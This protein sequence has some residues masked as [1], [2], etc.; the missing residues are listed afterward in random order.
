MVARGLRNPWRFSF[1]RA[2]GSLV[3]GDVGQGEFEEIDVGVAG[4]YGWPCF[5][6]TTRRTATP[7]SC[8]SGTAAPVLT[9]S[10]SGD[11]FCSIT[12]GYVV[13]DPGLPTLLGRYVYGDF[14][15]SGLRSV[16]LAEPGL[17]RGRRAVGGLA[18]L[19]RR[20]RVRAD[21]GR[22]AGRPGLP[23]GG[24]G[25]VGL[26]VERARTGGPCRRHARLRIVRSRDRD[27]ERAADR[28]A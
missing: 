14:C 22:V 8:D 26:H 6:G 23:A 15:A 16:D 13:R 4:N 19:V 27:A 9:K 18:E 11:G 2:N 12:G 24:R 7:A 10:H 25:A 17:G 21:A 3:I 20:G 1:D 28:A 5:E